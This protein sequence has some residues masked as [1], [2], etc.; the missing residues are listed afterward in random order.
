MRQDEGV[1]QKAPLDTAEALEAAVQ[2]GTKLCK[3]FGDAWNYIR[4]VEYDPQNGNHEWQ[5]ICRLCDRTL[6]DAVLM[7]CACPKCSHLAP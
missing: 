2:T 3:L 4:T 5:H 7:W 6:N 1:K